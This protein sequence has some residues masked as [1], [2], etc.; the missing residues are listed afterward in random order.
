MRFNR[1]EPSLAGEPLVAHQPQATPTLARPPR[2]RA[3]CHRAVTILLDV[4]DDSPRVQSLE[5]V[6]MPE[7][8]QQLE[9]LHDR[10]RAALQRR[11]SHSK[12]IR[13][14]A[15]V[16]VVQSRPNPTHGTDLTARSVAPMPHLD[17]QRKILS[18]LLWKIHPHPRICPVIAGDTTYCV[19]LLT[20][21]T[22]GSN[23]AFPSTKFRLTGMR[24][25]VKKSAEAV[26][27]TLAKPEVTRPVVST[28]TE[29]EIKTF[30]PRSLPSE[31]RRPEIPIKKTGLA[32]SPKPES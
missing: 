22:D 10:G 1:R 26:K 28:K 2:H 25:N 5:R 27:R 20:G 12:F 32:I 15:P 23:F 19:S 7:R 13:A 11:V 4:V 21:T 8:V 16:V 17:T 14:L 29:T 24:R 30:G 9:R 18:I 6:Q 31:S 3:R